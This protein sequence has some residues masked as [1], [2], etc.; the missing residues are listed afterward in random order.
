MNGIDKNPEKLDTLDT[1]DA[2]ESLDTPN[3]FRILL[4]EKAISELEKLFNNLKIQKRKEYQ[5][6]FRT[7]AGEMQ[8]VKYSYL[9]PKDLIEFES[10]KNIVQNAEK[11]KREVKDL[12]KDNFVVQAL[13][14]LDYLTSLPKLILKGRISKP[15]QAIKF[16]RGEIVSRSKINGL[17]VCTVDCGFKLNV[18]TNNETFK[19]G[20]IALIALLP[21][22][23]FRK[24]LSEGMFVSL[25][26]GERGEVQAEIIP[27]SE[28]REVDSVILELLK[29]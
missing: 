28:V 15:S 20:K 5:R 17:W 14:W 11:I 12:E 18:I 22:R 24:Y 27:E 6:K 13:Y 3:D 2:L 9:S 7:L 21:P 19:P 10:F 29:E 8:N 23:A 1:L 4:S 25:S 16:Y 26:E